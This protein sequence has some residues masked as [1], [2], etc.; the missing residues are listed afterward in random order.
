[1]ASDAAASKLAHVVT[2]ATERWPVP[3]D[4]KH[5]LLL[6][7]ADTP[8]SWKVATLLEELG[9]PYDL[10][11][12]DIMK[13]QQKD[14]AYTEMNPNGRTPTLLD[15]SVS[16]QFAVFESNAI[17]LYLADKYK[18]PLL[19]RDATRRSEVVQWLMWQISALGPVLGQV[20]FMRRIA[21]CANDAATLKFATERFHAESMRLL[22]VLDAR[23]AAR[24]YLCGPGRGEYT[25]ADIACWGYAAQHWWAGLS[26]DALPHLKRWVQAVGSRAAVRAGAR[27]PGVSVLG[28]K[29]PIFETMRTDAA[30]REALEARA[31]QRGAGAAGFNW[32]DMKALAG[33]DQSVEVWTAWGFREQRSAEDEMLKEAAAWPKVE[34]PGLKWLVAL[35]VALVALAVGM[36]MELKRRGA[37]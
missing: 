3:S 24:D 5:D 15:R 8:N 12:V 35:W 6:Y 23:L 2:T 19:P 1:M 36:V 7:A 28:P 14:P 20:M 29:A 9:L 4:A 27:V 21:S 26:V 32:D 10:A 18:S 33:L 11:I 17:L 25:L 31:A 30:V 13:N 34:G 37:A 16:P 22:A